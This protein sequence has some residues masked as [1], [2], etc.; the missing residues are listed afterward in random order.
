MAK[1]QERGPVLR[2][3]GGKEL[4]KS[5]NAGHIRKKPLDPDTTAAVSELASAEPAAHPL[6][7]KWCPRTKGKTPN[8]SVPC[9]HVDP[10]CHLRIPSFLV[11][12]TAGKQQQQDLG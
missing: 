6:A 8:I 3:K 2:R 1:G 10:S 5:R 11:H 4:H 12:H 7:N 9:C